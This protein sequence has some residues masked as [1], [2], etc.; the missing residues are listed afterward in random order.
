MKHL[1]IYAHFNETSLNASIQK[2]YV[3]KL[4]SK[5][6]EVVIRDLYAMKFDPTLSLQDMTANHAGALPADILL[7]QEY[8]RQ[9]DVITV[10]APIWWTGF[11]AILKGYFD[12][13]LLYGFAYSYNESGIVQ[14]LKNKKAVIINTTGQPKEVYEP[15]MFNAIKLTSDMGVFGFCGI[16]TIEHAFY[17]S[18]MSASKEVA[19][20]YINDAVSIVDRLF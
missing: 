7:E 13:V 2:A 8:V 18:A 6:H 19:E 4:Q 11:P 14:P 10:I 20:G 17:S 12:R 15:H 16:E 1:I 3:E 5:G 9:A